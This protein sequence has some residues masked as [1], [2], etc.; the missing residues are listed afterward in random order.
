MKKIKS[1]YFS[2]PALQ[3]LRTLVVA[4]LAGMGGTGWVLATDISPSPIFTATTATT[5]VKPNVMFVLDDSGSMSWTHMPDQANN[6]KGRYGYTSSHCNGVYY[7]PNITYTPPVNAAG[8]SM[9]NASFYAA[10]YDGY[11][12]AVGTLNTST[13][14]GTVDLSSD[15]EPDRFVPYSA[16]STYSGYRLP[17]GQSAAF[18]YVYSGTQ[19]T[20]KQKNYYDSN[21]I[22]YKECR[23]A[24]DS[25]TRV[26]GTNEV[27]S[28]FTRKVVSATSG[29]GGA[30]E[31]TNFA[32]WYSY[33]RTRM[34]MMKTSSGLAFKTL[35]DHF[36][37]GFLSI[38]N[39]ASPAFLNIDHFDSD[40]KSNWYSKLYGSSAA[41][42]TPLRE[43]LADTGRMYADKISTLN[44]T[45]VS[46][47]VQY[48]CQQNYVILSTDGFWN[49]TDRDV[50]KL[51]GSTT[52]GNEDGTLPR[53][54]FDGTSTTFQ[55]S[56]SQLQLSQ[57]KT[58]ESTSQLQKKT[59]QIKQRITQIQQQTT[60]TQK[61]TGQ[62]YTRRSSNWGN[63]WGD[64]SA[65]STCDEDS[66]GSSRRQCQIFSL[67]SRTSTDSG[68]TWSSWVP[69]ASCSPYDGTETRTSDDGG[70]SWSPWSATDSCDRDTRGD[71]RR[72]CRTG[73]NRTECQLSQNWA[74]AA[75]CTPTR[76]GSSGNYEYTGGASAV[77][78]QV[79]TTPMTDVASCTPSATVTCNIDDTGWT[80]ASSCSAS[81]PTNGRTVSC[82]VTDT[83]WV[84]AGSCSASASGGQ[85]VDC[86][87]ITTGPTAVAS[88]TPQT[89]ASGNS[90]LQRTCSSAVISG[91]TGVASC[92]AIAPNAGNGNVA[93]TCN[94]V[95]TGPTTT[96]SC[97][98]AVA[99]ASNNYTATTCSGATVS[100]GTANTLADVAAYYYNNN[101][102][103]SALGNCTGPV[104]HP[105]TTATDLCEANTVPANGLDTAT[106]Q[107][108]TTFTL[109]LGARGKM[110]FS[111][112][113]LTDTAGD[114]F[115]VLKG[116][117][118]GANNCSWQ[119]ASGTPC[120][121]PTPGQDKVENI[122][123]LWH[124]AVNGHGNY[125]SATDPA[126]LTNALS[127]SLNVIINTPQPGTAAAAATTNPKITS[128]NNFQFSSFFKSVEWSGELIR[129]SMSLTDGSVPSYNHMNPDPTKY[130]WSAQTQL[131]AKA[132]DSRQIY[133][134]GSSG[135]INF[136]WANLGTAG[137]QAYFRTPHI[138]TSPPSPLTGLSQFCATGTD[139]ISATAQSN[140]T[141]AAG[142]AAGEALVNFLRGDRSNEEGPVTDPSKYFRNR[143]HV[144]GDI[145]SAQPQ[146][147]G[148]PDRS[149]ADS[150][151]AAFKTAQAARAAVVYVAANDGMLHAFDA[152][153][154]N[155]NWAYIP[156]FVLPKLFTLS[157]KKY[158]NKHQY[159]VEGAPKTGDV[160]I[161]GDW[162]TILVGGLNAGGVGYYALDITDP[163]T[164]VLLWE[165]SDADM[166]LGFGNPEIT[167]QDDGTWVVLLTSGYN[168]GGNGY[169]YVI[170]AGTGA[171][172]Q[173]IST[174]VGGSS[175][176]S[177]IIAKGKS[178]T[179]NTTTHVYGGD[180]LGNLWRFTIEATGANG[181]SKQLLATFKDASGT[182][183]PI[184]ARPQVTVYKGQTL[185][186]AGTGRYLGT[187]DVGNTQQQSFYGVKD[188]VTTTAYTSIRSDG[189]FIKKTAV[190]GV[191][192]T[193]TNIEI[194]DSGTQVRTVSLNTG[195][196]AAD[197]FDTKN[198]WF[199][200]FPLN[201]GELQFTDSKLTRG[202]L[203]FS[204][205]VPVASSAAVCGKAD[206]ADPRAFAYMLDYLTGGAVG[207]PTGIIATTLGTG[208]ATAPQI[209]QLP[210]GV[211]LNKYRLSS[212]V[213][214]IV[215]QRY[216]SSSGSNLTR[217]ISW[218]ELVRE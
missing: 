190:D 65:V 218:R 62:L 119:I 154:G 90:W 21:S 79:T 106:W 17:Y 83:G 91:P 127:S 163:A 136:T 208:I 112:T 19:T 44:G 156:S 71:D 69:N 161:N 184:T 166:G 33:Y 41:G 55:K 86:Q 196:A 108:M 10:Q 56:T 178:V 60:E 104:I 105:A 42:G 121:W 113:Y 142:G 72:Q 143:T 12:T 25:T 30:D 51:D 128:A 144:L 73:S 53:P 177:R 187:T 47:P 173:K 130:D 203:A 22:F 181:Y 8:S 162:R 120:D 115:D 172:K 211:V 67:E 49:G 174:G 28:L 194:C 132:Y 200:D 125:F 157:D 186:F 40:H 26:D 111:P 87:T 198:G 32:N 68:S 92:T 43:A 75:S 88:C 18:Y 197:S 207:T 152:A 150:G 124:A 66:S 101:L 215:K 202:T 185:V 169:L 24:I 35:D 193:G 117:T 123:D 14:K 100:G 50:K 1:P 5:E 212:G 176:L 135:L 102:R 164:P 210:D 52:M 7:N 57:T 80:N 63:S 216:S 168:N 46:N 158:S 89:A 126:T 82:D 27:R 137:L 107:H 15:F 165:F 76:T 175:G 133:T 29:P 16:N 85:T 155:E 2:A 3:A 38:N 74:P 182:P 6:F 70:D 160:Y 118:A 151:Y 149:Y 59:T 199:V 192:P 77:D 146:Y 206:A 189:T 34:Q 167:K 145:V 54:Y 129:Q 205:S 217:R 188:N 103:T 183:Q 36:R 98:A 94:T 37:V 138:S 122:D 110:V 95:T 213:E 204:T 20:E 81:G 191:C 23:S 9:G 48:S 64:W 148:K 214:V 109:G 134:K 159:F 131:D 179:D 171:A 97:T 61:L 140:T 153:T 31:R 39:N 195:T 99:S 180:L 93:T 58:T 201:S 116:N 4:G 13:G 114:Y 170:N 139:C 45:T 96:A 84:G 147:V 78:C 141:V 11:N 209:S